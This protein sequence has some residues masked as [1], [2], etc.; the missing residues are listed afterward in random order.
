MKKT[1]FNPGAINMHKLPVITSRRIFGA[2]RTGQRVTSAYLKGDDD[3]DDGSEEKL[4]IQRIKKSV[5][6]ELATRA[7]AE[8][9]AEIVK[10]LEFLKPKD[11]SGGFPIEALRTMADP[12]NGVMVMLANQG[13]EIQNLKTSMNSLPKDMSVRAQVAAYREKNKQVIDD[14]KN[15]TQRNLPPF[16]LDLRVAA[17]PM[18]AASVMPSGSTYISRQ[19]VRPGIINDLRAEPTFWDFIKKGTTNAETYVWVNKLPTEGAAGFIGPGVFKP[20]ISFSFEAEISNAKKVADSAKMPT[21]LLEDIDG[22]AS[23]VED[24]LRYMVMQKVNDTLMTGV[25]SSTVPAGVQTLSVAYDPLTGVETTDPN[26]WDAVKAA[27]TQLRVSRFKGPIVTFMNPVDLANAVMTKAVGQGQ[28]FIPPATGSTIVEDLNIP[29]GF[30]QVVAMDYYKILIYR[31]FRIAWGWEND[32]FTKN[33]VT[34]IG[35]MRL[36][37]FHSANHDG[38][39][40]YDELSTIRT[41]ITAA[42]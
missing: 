38:F 27:V 36:H 37:Q 13:L 29:L 26:N 28:L 16:E 6:K 25:A 19:E 3:D 35:E 7:S 39:A 34:A 2:S 24:E 22:F 17:Y 4:L 41:A 14:I 8:E 10:Q 40:I 32:D 20:S 21:E 30:I 18:T 23:W 15:G 42:A 5:S 33:L 1:Y 31:G 9:V 12:T 11:G